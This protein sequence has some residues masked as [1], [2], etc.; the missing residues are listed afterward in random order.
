MKPC[1]N[2]SISWEKGV[3]KDSKKTA[4]KRTKGEETVVAR[5]QSRAY[6]CIHLKAKAEDNGNTDRVILLPE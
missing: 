4:M 2:Q 3:K 6:D 5:Q 1:E